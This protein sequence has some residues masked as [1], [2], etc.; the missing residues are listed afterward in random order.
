MKNILFSVL[1]Y[2]SFCS[3]YPQDTPISVPKDLNGC[4]SALE[5]LLSEESKLQILNMEESE[6]FSLHFGLG[7]WIRN[8][9]GLWKGSDLSVWFNDRGIYHPDDMSGIILR[10]YW[11]QMH[12]K[13]L[14]FEA[15]IQYYRD[16]WDGLQPSQLD[17]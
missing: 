13:P 7:M 1:L 16:Y 14:E 15:Q 4:F 8:N 11:L 6:I 2:L 12:G 10:S 5:T 17:E 9:W 3:L